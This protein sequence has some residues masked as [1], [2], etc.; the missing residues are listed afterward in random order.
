MRASC[1]S[2][3]E[4]ARVRRELT[5]FGWI[6]DPEIAGAR[7]QSPSYLYRVKQ[8]TRQ[9]FCYPPRTPQKVVS[10]VIMRSLGRSCVVRSR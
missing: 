4:W 10:G 9:W 2:E 6:Q 8:Y 5:A 7:A 1:E 3:A